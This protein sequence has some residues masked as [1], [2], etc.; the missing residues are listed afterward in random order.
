MVEALITRLRRLATLLALLALPAAVFAHRLDECLQATIVAIEPGDIRLRIHLTPGV[1]VAGQILAKIDH[2]GDGVISGSESTA[3]AALVQRDL[4][5]R[6]DGRDL[7]LKLT[8][9]RFPPPAELRS[10]DGI[11]QLEFIATDPR[12]V[13]GAH[14]LALE[15]R[16][17]VTISVYLLNAARPK[18]PAI[19]ILSQ[20]RA[21]N[22][23]AG[24]IE[25]TVSSAGA[26][27]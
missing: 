11:I 7:K 18:S 5:L 9:S 19:Q 27:N 8:A 3:Y 24:E 2:D 17:L 4:T 22:Q 13:P 25:F 1:E 10:G 12:L 16:H 23:A 14:Q 21:A 20:K 6:L 15:N 26:P